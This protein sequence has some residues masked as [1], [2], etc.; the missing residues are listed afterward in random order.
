MDG[1]RVS[2]L[3]FSSGDPKSLIDKGS[4]YWKYT[5]VDRGVRFVTWYDYTVRFGLA[6]QI[7]DRFVFRKLL[8]WAT[9]WSFDRLRLWLE[10]GI[11]PEASKGAAIAHHA[12][13]LG[14]GLCWLYQGVIPKLLDAESGEVEI[15]MAGGLTRGRAKA[16]VTGAGVAETAIGIAC[17]AKPRSRWPLIATL[18]ALPMLG[19]AIARTQPRLFSR[20][21]SPGSLSLA[22]GALCLAALAAVPHSPSASR[23]LREP[24]REQ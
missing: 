2:A 4:G 24:G 20:P 1:S 21:F 19:M 11:A 23:C 14:V 22:M 10:K 18:A 8:G 7:A 15:A 16:F 13:R 3:R 9:A 12:G 5:P 6:G 17:L